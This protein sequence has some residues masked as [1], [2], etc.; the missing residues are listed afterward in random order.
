MKAT[1]L[2]N[3]MEV[4]ITR[5]M[6]D[7][8]RDDWNMTCFAAG[9][10]AISTD[11]CARLMAVLYVHGNNELMTHHKGFLA[12]VR[13]I[14]MRYHLHGGGMPDADFVE[15][16]KEYVS[17]LENADNKPI[18]SDSDALFH[19]NIPTWAKGLYN[20]RYGIKLIN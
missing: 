1:A 10:P 6:V 8:M 16:L 20:R 15:L 2:D 14:Q 5:E 11:T 9:I 7:Q 3:M 18:D 17:E 19:R 13:Y 4:G 12:D